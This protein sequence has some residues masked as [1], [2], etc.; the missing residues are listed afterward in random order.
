MP[1]TRP[2]SPQDPAATDTASLT[3]LLSDC[4]ALWDIIR[5]PP[6]YTARRRP[7]AA[8][9]PHRRDDPSLAGTP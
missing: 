9:R 1:D 3:G 2:G 5:A 6:G 4:G 7:R 8:G